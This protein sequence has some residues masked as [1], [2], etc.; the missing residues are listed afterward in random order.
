MSGGLSEKIGV[1]PWKVVDGSDV[2]SLDDITAAV[3]SDAI[4]ILDGSTSVDICVEEKT[5]LGL[6]KIFNE[7]SPDKNYSLKLVRVMNK[8]RWYDNGRIL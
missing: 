3:N 8:K 7:V 5:I 4:M 2:T 1:V 6:I